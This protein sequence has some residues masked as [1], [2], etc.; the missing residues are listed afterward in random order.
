MPK[1]WLIVNKSLIGSAKNTRATR[2]RTNENPKRGHPM[3]SRKS[4]SPP[5]DYFRR[6]MAR[7]YSWKAGGSPNSYNNFGFLLESSELGFPGQA[8]VE[9]SV[10]FDIT[11]PLFLSLWPINSNDPEYWA[12]VSALNT[13]QASLVMASL[14]GATRPGAEVQFGGWP[15]QISHEEVQLTLEAD[16]GAWLLA[17]QSNGISN[18]PKELSSPLPG[19]QLGWYNW[20]AYVLGDDAIEFDGAGRKFPGIFGPGMVDN[21]FYDH[22]FERQTPDQLVAQSNFNYYNSFFDTLKDN[23]N[24]LETHIPNFYVASSLLYGPGGYYYAPADGTPE[25]LYYDLH[26]DFFLSTDSINSI[27]GILS[28][29]MSD[30]TD[31]NN[32]DILDVVSP[33]G[34]LTT[35]QVAAASQIPNSLLSRVARF[36]FSSTGNTADL[37][38]AHEIN[39]HIGIPRKMLLGGQQSIVKA[40]DGHRQLFPYSI[41]VNLEDSLVVASE[42]IAEIETVNTSFLGGDLSP[43]SQI[44]S[45]FFLYE[46]MKANILN[47]ANASNLAT[48]TPAGDSLGDRVYEE[49]NVSARLENLNPGETGDLPAYYGF[50]WTNPGPWNENVEAREPYYLR[51]IDLKNLFRNIFE[52]TVQ[53]GGPPLGS[54]GYASEDS[55]GTPIPESYSGFIGQSESKNVAVGSGLIVGERLNTSIE[56]EANLAVALNTSVLSNEF[57]NYADYLDLFVQVSDFLNDKVR[58]FGSMIGGSKCYRDTLAYK[59]DKHSV[60][61]DGQVSAE[62]LQSIYF[63]NT[64]D[65]HDYVDTQVFFGK[66]YMYKLYAYDLVVGNEYKYTDPHVFP[67][68]ELPYPNPLASYLGTTQNIGTNYPH[69]TP[70]IALDNDPSHMALYWPRN[71]IGQ[72]QSSGHAMYVDLIIAG[73]HRSSTVSLPGFP[74]GHDGAPLNVVL[75]YASAFRE[76]LQNKIN[77]MIDDYIWENYEP[78]GS[79]NRRRY[80]TKFRVSLLVEDTRI[81]YEAQT[82]MRLFIAQVRNLEANGYGS[83][84]QL[85]MVNMVKTNTAGL[86]ANSTLQVPNPSGIPAAQEPNAYQAYFDL[87]PLFTSYAGSGWGSEGGMDVLVAL[88]TGEHGLEPVIPWDDTD[89]GKANVSVFNYKSTKIIEV[90]LTET[91][92]IQVT[93]LPPQYPDAEIFPLKGSARRLK[94]LVS[95]NFTKATYVPIV[96]EPTDTQIFE[97]VRI[98]QGQP[99]DSPILFGSDDLRTNYQIFRTTEKPNTY[100]DFAGKLHLEKD[101]ETPEGKRVESVSI[102]DN[103]D[104]N[105]YYYYCFRAIDKNGYISNPSPILRVQMVDDNGRIYPIIEPYDFDLNDP[106]KTE[107]PFKRYL[108]IDASLQ[109]KVIVPTGPEPHT[110][111]GTPNEAPTSVSMGTSE[112]TFGSTNNYKVRIISKDTGRKIDLNLHFN[113]ETIPNPN[114]PGN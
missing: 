57:N 113:V 51:T 25:N 2:W 13:V 24:V 50:Q 78:T 20:Q 84:G 18:W 29:T 12:I 28:K 14:F 21:L 54:P 68:I 30:T 3:V 91:N 95:S 108:E 110:T 43:D 34:N 48:I 53:M 100:Q 9:Y 26:A 71:D 62:A 44:L 10:A 66:K 72:G 37:Q 93:D 77:E 19:G 11:D 60:D 35:G 23:P 55:N 58:S 92:V 79:F 1:K 85:D 67:P 41:V 6:C 5:N 112:G 75:K 104:P 65:A 52:Y 103:I 101:G 86:T 114:L 99:A 15:A 73:E 64:G 56:P 22:A 97:N 102:L 80:F 89:A 32:V 107:K 46:I 76:N 40:M 45:N 82:H 106:R 33:S 7:Y 70:P 4:S 38:S 59:L 111:A 88:R 31:P 98:T 63:A 36:D 61:D 74:A 96:I 49:M 81:R 109:E 90:P 39:R 17:S 105:T 94:I 27:K 42:L 87:D 16:L 69:L 83:Q 47:F 8:S